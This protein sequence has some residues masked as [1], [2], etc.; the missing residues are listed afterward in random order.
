MHAWLKRLEKLTVGITGI[1][2]HMTLKT[3]PSSKVWGG[4]IVYNATYQ[5]RLMQA[6]ANYQ[7]DGQKDV[8][9]AL[10][11]YLLINNG[12][13]LLTLVYLDD[14]EKPKAFQPFY[15]IPAIKDDTK[16]YNNLIEIIDQPL[17][18]GVPRFGLVFERDYK[19]ALTIVR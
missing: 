15:D 8:N 9:S 13:L 6:F 4:T 17:P 10:I 14:T 5:D 18:Q 2:T 19:P 12:T 11:S 3:Y 7:Q 1:V 16:I